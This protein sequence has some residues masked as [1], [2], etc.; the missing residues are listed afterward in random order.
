MQVKYF[1]YIRDF[2][3][4]KESI[5]EYKP[6]IKELLHSLADKYGDKFKNEALTPDGNDL[7]ER[8]IILI[9]GRHVAHL[10]GI[11][12]KINESDIVQVFPVVAGG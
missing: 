1:A 9:N 6:T 7:G 12:A 5:E 3:K 10:G 8:I 4:C 2:T 11:N